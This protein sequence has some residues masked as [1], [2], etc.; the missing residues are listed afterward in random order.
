MKLTKELYL[1]KRMNYEYVLFKVAVVYF[2]IVTA[3]VEFFS[4]VQNKGW[5][6]KL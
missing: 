4:I 2:I 6:F 5:L 1:V 3:E